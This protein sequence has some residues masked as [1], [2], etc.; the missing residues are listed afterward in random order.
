MKTILA[1]V[2]LS[3]V[4]DLVEAEA[5]ELGQQLVQSGQMAAA[6]TRG[7]RCIHRLNARRAGAT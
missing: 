2:D 6:L 3:R 5:A 4:T 7:C 1:A